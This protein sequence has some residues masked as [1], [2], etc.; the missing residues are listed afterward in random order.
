MTPTQP[1]YNVQQNQRPTGGQPS[2]NLNGDKRDNTARSP[3]A[4]SFVL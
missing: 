1:N 3:L 2:V 4:D